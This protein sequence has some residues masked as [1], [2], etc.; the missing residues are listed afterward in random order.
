METP[1]I[2]KLG[3]ADASLRPALP[4]PWRTAT[5]RVVLACWAVPLVVGLALFG[6]ALVLGREMPTS[7]GDAGEMNI[8]AGTAL[9]GVGG[10]AVVV[11]AAGR[12][13]RAAGD[14]WRLV[15]RPALAGSALLASNF[16][17][18]ALLIVILVVS[19]RI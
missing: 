13:C 1:L 3:Y 5:L 2:A 19:D 16:V 9:A 14:R 17:V 6:T 11:F 15:V 7:V 18:A 10:A 12:W 4:P 8:Y